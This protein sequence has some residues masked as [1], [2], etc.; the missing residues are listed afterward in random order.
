M[1]LEDLGI[2]VGQLDGVVQDLEVE[3][4][5]LTDTPVVLL[6]TVSAVYI[7]LY[8]FRAMRV[9]YTQGRMLTALKYVTLGLAYFTSLLLMLL[10]TVTVTAISL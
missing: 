4:D 1:L 7:P 2:Q 5:R 8:L 9:V 10:A 3:G 6:N